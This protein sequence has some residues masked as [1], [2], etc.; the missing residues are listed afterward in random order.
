MT[1]CT[2]E[3]EGWQILEGDRGRY[4][5]ACGCREVPAEAVEEAAK[6]QWERTHSMP[7]TAAGYGF[8]LP[9]LREA[10]EALQAEVP[11]E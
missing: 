4:C 2:H 8:K 6:A 1:A 5:G 9:Y 10:R 7:W 3:C 11:G